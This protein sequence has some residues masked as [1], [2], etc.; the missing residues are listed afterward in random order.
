M[1]IVVAIHSGGGNY[2]DGVAI[3]NAL[4]ARRDVTVRV[5]GLAASAASYIAMAARKIIMTRSSRLMIHSPM[6]GVRGNPAEIQTTLNVLRE[7]ETEMAVTYAGRSNLTPVEMLKLMRQETWF[8]PQEAQQIFRGI[9]VDDMKVAAS[10]NPEWLKSFTNIP[11]DLA[12]DLHTAAAKPKPKV[13][14]GEQRAAKK[15]RAARRKRLMLWRL[16]ES[17]TQS[18][19]SGNGSA[20]DSKS[21]PSCLLA[22]IPDEQKA[23]NVL[24]PRRHA[25]A[26]GARNPAA[27][28]S[29]CRRSD[30]SRRGGVEREALQSFVARSSR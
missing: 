16:R 21:G 14:A 17:W 12:V 9:E 26:R 8:T 29:G 30:R 6:V 24:E 13:S 7:M 15:R 10:I 2:L 11:L 25:G 20:I 4:K 27:A 1:P 18:R 19:P 23:Q 28:R 3:Y 5:D 22:R